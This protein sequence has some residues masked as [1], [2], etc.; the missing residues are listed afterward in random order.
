[1]NNNQFLEIKGTIETGLGKGQQF[2]SLPEYQQQFQEHLNFT[3]F[4]GT[5]NLKI[6]PI[7]LP[8]STKKTIPEFTVNQ[9]TFGAVDCYPILIKNTQGAII[10]PKQTTH[11]NTTIE[12]ISPVKLRD[13]YNLHDNDKITIKV[14]Q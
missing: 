14:K 1:M 9:Q 12:I 4:A 11:D 8:Q 2:M 3:P 13:Q 7:Q 10:I 5:L 6:T